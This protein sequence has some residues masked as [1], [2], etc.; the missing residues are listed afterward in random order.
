MQLTCSSTPTARGVRTR[1]LPKP[2][3]SPTA[4]T[5]TQVRANDFRNVRLFSLCASHAIGPC[6]LS[7]HR[8]N[9]GALQHKTPSSSQHHHRTPT[10]WRRGMVTTMATRVDDVLLPRTRHTFLK[11]AFLAC[12]SKFQPTESYGYMRIHPLH[13]PYT[14]CTM[15]SAIAKPAHRECPLKPVLSL[16][17]CCADSCGV[18]LCRPRAFG[19]VFSWAYRGPALFGM[20]IIIIKLIAYP[21]HTIACA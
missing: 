11:C 4:L 15:A 1:A 5:I 9:Q 20:P 19:R 16:V 6:E 3:R 10:G 18:T 7:G 12:A 21:H 13:Y 2:Y 17:P 8:D 14:A